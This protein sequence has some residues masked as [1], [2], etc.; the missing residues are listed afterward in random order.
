MAKLN[1]NRPNNGYEPEP[2]AKRKYKNKASVA[3]NKTINQESVFISGKY[4]NK[5]IGRIIDQDPAYCEWILVNQPR[6]TVA[7]QIIKYFNK[8]QLTK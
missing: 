1:Y 6:G 5:D 4:W 2:W 7:K 3:F 8:N